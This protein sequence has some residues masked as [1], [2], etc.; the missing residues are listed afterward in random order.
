MF[1]DHEGRL[2]PAWS[3]LLS[4]ALTAVVLFASG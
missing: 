2:Y 1:T 3:F 4:V